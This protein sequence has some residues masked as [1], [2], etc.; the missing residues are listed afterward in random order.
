[1][2][3]LLQIG[4]TSITDTTARV[5]IIAVLTLCVMFTARALYHRKHAKIRHRTLAAL[6][7]SVAFTFVVWLVMDVWWDPFPE[8]VPWFIYVSGGLAA[9]VLFSVIVQ[10]GRRKTGVIIAVIAVAFAWGLS[11][12][13]YKQ[14][15]TVRSLV[16]EPKTVAM[17]YAQFKQQKDVPTLHGREVGALVTVDI[18]AP[19]SGFHHRDAVAYFPPAYFAEPDKDLPVVVLMAGNPGTPMQWFRAGGAEQTLDDY[20]TEHKGVAPIVISVDATGSL[21]ANPICVDGPEAKVQTYLA[22]DVPAQIK[23]KFRVNPDQSRWTIGGLSYGGTCALQV[24]TNAPEAYGTFLDFSGQAEP[25][26]GDHT[27]TV[28]Q[29]FGGD[30]A[31][32]QAVNPEHLLQHAAQL[33]AQGQPSPY[34][35]IDGRFIAGSEDKNSVEALKHLNELAQAAGM[36]TTFATVGG[37]HSYQ[38][39][40]EAFRE[41]M[42]FLAQ[43][44]NLQ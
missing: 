15:P 28:E 6:A 23:S 39:W 8:E 34:A 21:S 5:V 22:V 31:A 40:R 24:I 19:V 44:E 36:H 35:H 43:R 33:V 20:Q 32:F 41:V 17:D 37:G 1:M 26:I 30:E 9:F 29:F 13:V 3:E 4:E 16:P 18:E 10:T 7:V 27:K 38:T 25:T 2:N 12:T 14:F 11:N 42:N